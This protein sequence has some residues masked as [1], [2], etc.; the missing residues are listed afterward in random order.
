MSKW[1]Y[2]LAAAMMLAVPEASFSQSPKGSDYSHD[3]V[4]NYLIEQDGFVRTRAV[5]IGTKSECAASKPAAKGFDMML[6]FD[7]DSARLTEAA[8]RNL[9]VISEALTDGRLNAARFRIEGHTDARGGAEYN[10]SLSMER[11]DAVVRYLEEKNV[12]ADRLE[13]IGFGKSAPR[14]SNPFDSENRRVELKLV[15]Q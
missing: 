4:V 15:T 2:C 6:T 10:M 5:C 1:L 8:R 11:A 13:A 12:P 9:D 3:D 14:T 7:L